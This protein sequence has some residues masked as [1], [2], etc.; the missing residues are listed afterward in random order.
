MGANWGR[1]T[2]YFTYVDLVSE[3]VSMRV[4]K[5]MNVPINTPMTNTVPFEGFS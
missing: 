5:K 2:A 1:S 3:D 4:K